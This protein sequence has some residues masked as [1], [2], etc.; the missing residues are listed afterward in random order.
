MNRF[1]FGI[2]RGGSTILGKIC[3]EV[4]NQHKIPLQI[5]GNS[6]KQPQ[7]F[8]EI[9]DDGACS[10]VLNVKGERIND[11]YGLPSLKANIGNWESRKD[12]FFA[13]I[14]NAK[15][16]TADF[17][18]EDDYGI[19]NI[20][21]PRDCMTSGYYGFLLLHGQKQHS[22]VKKEMFEKG[23]DAYVIDSLL[24]RFETKLNDYIELINTL[25]YSSRFSI[26][27]YE[28]M[29]CDFPKWF[30]S[31]CHKLEIDHTKSQDLEKSLAEN[32]RPVQ[33]EDIYKHKRQM[34]PGDYQNKLKPE[35]INLINERLKD[36]LE[37]F[38][39]L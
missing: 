16:F 6:K 21:D 14:R 18:K 36:Q 2:H 31:F 26:L 3:R 19:L 11:I 27:K 20:R 13:P 1:A 39:Y 7:L 24:G 8:G 38:G 33:K 17:F 37:F 35:T 4:A 5:L 15:Y 22:P 9:G 12:S 29:V 10:Y 23:I 30:K 34:L 25:H 32:F 28:M